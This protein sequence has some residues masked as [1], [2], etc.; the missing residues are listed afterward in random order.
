MNR[1]I[2]RFKKSAVGRSVLTLPKS[3]RKKIIAI[4]F[5]QISLGILDL[6]G[7]VAIGLLGALSA[8]GLQVK[9]PDGKIRST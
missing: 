7:V 8:A 9:A 5:V 1:F 2:D 4:T 6:L 3:D